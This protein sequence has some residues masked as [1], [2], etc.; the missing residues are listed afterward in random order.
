ML[1]NEYENKVLSNRNKLICRCLLRL[2]EIFFHMYI[3]SSI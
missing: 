1:K 3:I 2:L